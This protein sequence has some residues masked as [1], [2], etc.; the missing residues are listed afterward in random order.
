M[1]IA[2]SFKEL[3]EWYQFL[4]TRVAEDVLRRLSDDFYVFDRSKLDLGSSTRDGHEA[5]QFK[6]KL[7]F[8][9][10]NDNALGGRGNPTFINLAG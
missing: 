6:N 3:D 4:R 9:V 2:P 1:I 8:T 5:P 7:I 10:L